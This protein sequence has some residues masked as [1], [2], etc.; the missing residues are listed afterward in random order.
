[1][2]SAI[3]RHSPQSITSRRRV[4]ERAEA[5][6]LARI[7]ESVSIPQLCQVAA[8]SERSLRN[9]FYAVRGMSPKRSVVRLGS[10]KCDVL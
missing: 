6:L 2:A 4:V 7:G 10:P 5:F 3:I 8:V 1:M 9:A